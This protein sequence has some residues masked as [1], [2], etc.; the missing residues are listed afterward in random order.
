MPNIIKL[1]VVV[2]SVVSPL[3]GLAILTKR[4]MPIFWPEQSILESSFA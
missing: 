2:L 3:I 1:C 4:K